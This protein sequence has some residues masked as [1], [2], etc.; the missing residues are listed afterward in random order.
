MLIPALG[1]RTILTPFLTFSL[2][3]SSRQVVWDR[4]LRR[5]RRERRRTGPSSEVTGGRKP[6]PRPR[7]SSSVQTLELYLGDETTNVLTSLLCSSFSVTGRTTSSS[8]SFRQW[9]LWTSSIYANVYKRLTWVGPYINTIKSTSGLLQHVLPTTSSV[10]I[11]KGKV[12]VG[13]HTN[14]SGT[15]SCPLHTHN[16]SPHTKLVKHP[17]SSSPNK[18]NY[19]LKDVEH[20]LKIL[21]KNK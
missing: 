11:P 12:T 10:L 3:G 1:C 18:G 2:F 7:D 14:L 6:R 20:F 21:C 17:T 5:T 15:H 16:V 9:V 13:P 4:S 8:V 19:C